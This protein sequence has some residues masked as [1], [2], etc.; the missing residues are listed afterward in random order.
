MNKRGIYCALFVQP[1]KLGQCRLMHSQK[2]STTKEQAKYAGRIY[3][4]TAVN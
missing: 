4:G 2:E 1:Y 3:K